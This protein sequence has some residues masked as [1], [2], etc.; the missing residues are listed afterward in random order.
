MA[1]LLSPQCADNSA[2]RK[3]NKKINSSTTSLSN[4]VFFL[5]SGIPAATSCVAAR[6]ATAESF[7]PTTVQHKKTTITHQKPTTVTNP[8][9]SYLLPLEQLC[10]LSFSSI[11]FNQHVSLL[12]FA[13]TRD[14]F[15]QGSP[16]YKCLLE[17][18][19]KKWQ[20]Q[21]ERQPSW[22]K[23]GRWTEKVCTPPSL[24]IRLFFSWF[25]WLFTTGASPWSLRS[26]G[27]LSAVP[28][29]R[30]R[31]LR[32]SFYKCLRATHA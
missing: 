21:R 18:D 20:V 8:K 14:A 6:T 22:G 25:S 16:K 19:M 4:N 7:T 28:A 9:K 30:W 5:S 13:L 31:E 27:W 2:K 26:P 17:L 23:M 24:K 1:E 12:S 10:V 32:F 15:Q 29:E 3:Q 11:N